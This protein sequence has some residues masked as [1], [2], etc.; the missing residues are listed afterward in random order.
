MPRPGMRTSVPG[1]S[2]SSGVRFSPLAASA[3]ALGS[4]AGSS[5]TG[6]AGALA[7]PPPPIVVSSKANAAW[8]VRPSSAATKMYLI[9]LIARPRRL[10][11]SDSRLRSSYIAPGILHDKPASTLVWVF[12][13]IRQQSVPPTPCYPNST[14]TSGRGDGGRRSLDCGKRIT[15]ARQPTSCISCRASLVP[16]G[17][18]PSS[19]VRY[20]GGAPMALES[21][22]SSAKYHVLPAAAV[23]A[24]GLSLT[25]AATPAAAAD[26][27]GNCCA[28]LEERVA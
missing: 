14:M 24:A 4:S 5:S 8:P 3:G 20:N 10:L 28:D 26:L 9:A 27:G 22:K 21:G 7:L 6:A 11:L 19:D 15:V 17:R 25:P 23:L 1:V 12:R 18:R 16:R 2:C 13:A